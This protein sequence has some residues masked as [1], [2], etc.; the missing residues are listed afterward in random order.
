MSRLFCLIVSVFVLLQGSSAFAN[1]FPLSYPSRPAE[2]QPPLFMLQ[3]GL[4]VLDPGHGGKDVGT[5]SISKPR[6][7]EKGL[8]LVTARQVRN[9]LQKL[10]YRVLMTR[11]DDTFVSLEKRAELANEW[12]PRVF[13]SIH[14]N[15]APSAEA[16]GIEVFYYLS[17]EDKSRT[18]QSKKMAQAV[19][20]QVIGE[21]DAKSRGVKNGNYA[22]IRETKMP[23]ILVEGGFVTNTDELKKLKDPTYIKKLAWG[24][25]KGIDEYLKRN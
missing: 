2:N 21:T 3:K 7:Q 4:V 5:Q 13:V 25:A 8:N 17:K 15:A 16:E 1:G 23:A 18:L 12:K 22:V 20:K 19:L 6:C 24:I 9:F 14:Y 10:G 11:N